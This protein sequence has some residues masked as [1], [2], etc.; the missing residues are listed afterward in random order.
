MPKLPM[1]GSFSGFLASCA[2][3]IAGD[4]IEARGRETTIYVQRLAR[5][6]GRSIARQKSD[7]P[8]HLVWLSHALHGLP[9]LEVFDVDWAG[10]LDQGG[11]DDARCH[12]VDADTEP[13]PLHRQVA[14]HL[15]HR[16]LG[17]AV[18]E[19]RRDVR[20]AGY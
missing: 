8:C 10:S 3:P 11:L 4:L 13:G 19:A 9:L 2:L 17:S 5:Y 12:G 6:K 16:G 1:G 14:G 18:G 15:I 20:A 7:G